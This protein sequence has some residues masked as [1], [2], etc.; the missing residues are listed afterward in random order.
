MRHS[1]PRRETRAVLAYSD[2]ARLIGA[3]HGTVKRWAREGLPRIG[4]RVLVEE[5]K[6]WIADVRYEDT[7]T[8]EPLYRYESPATL[9]EER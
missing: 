8:G 4:T 1:T 3:P 6:R 9:P 5:G 7:S 2:F